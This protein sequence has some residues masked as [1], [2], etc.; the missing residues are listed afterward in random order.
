MTKQGRQ[1]NNA[2]KYFPA[3]WVDVSTDAVAAHRVAAAAMVRRHYSVRST[4]SPDVVFYQYGTG[5]REFWW[6]VIGIDLIMRL[7]GRPDGW[8]QIA[9]WTTA[10]PGGTRIWVALID[11]VFHAD[12]VRSTIDELVIDVRAAGI[13]IAVGE[14]FSGLDLPADSPGQPNPR[15]KRRLARRAREE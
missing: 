10:V 2:L 15:R 1:R 11:G 13:L 6:D 8:A 5:A 12:A 9:V 14:P 7:M 4:A 3:C